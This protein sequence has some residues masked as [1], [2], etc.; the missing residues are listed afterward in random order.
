MKLHGS[1]I[2]FYPFFLYRCSSSAALPH[3]VLMENKAQGQ[4]SPGV[5]ITGPSP[6]RPNISLVILCLVVCNKNRHQLLQSRELLQYCRIQRH[7]TFFFLFSFF[8][9]PL[10]VLLLFL[11]HLLFYSPPLIPRF[12]SSAFRGGK[13]IMCNL[14][15]DKKK[16]LLVT[17]HKKKKKNPQLENLIL[18]S[19]GLYERVRDC[20]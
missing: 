16:M 15:L 14:G 11:F 4:N 2:Y 9:F 20:V 8:L 6:P 1:V 10:S 18:C 13:K 12:A 5:W 7:K 17:Y 3:R 19:E